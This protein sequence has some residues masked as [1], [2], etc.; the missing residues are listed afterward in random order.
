LGAGVGEGLGEAGGV[1]EVGR[2]VWVDWSG[3]WE[4][5]VGLSFGLTTEVGLS[6]GFTTEVGLSFGFTTEVGLSFGFT[7]GVGLSFGFTTEVGFPW[8]GFPGVGQ[9]SMVLV[10]VTVSV[11]KTVT[12]E[13]TGVGGV[14]V[15]GGWLDPLESVPEGSTTRLGPTETLEP[16]EGLTVAG[17]LLE[18]LGGGWTLYGP[19]YI[20]LLCAWATAAKKRVKRVP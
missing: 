15:K 14:V 18:L 3:D 13:I 11:L 20:M 17:R 12:Y 7:T 10:L 19:S 1:T 6:F 5:V 16:R 8:F 2:R 9:D 4:V